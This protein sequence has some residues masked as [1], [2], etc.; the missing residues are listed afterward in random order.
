MNELIES[1]KQLRYTLSLTDD[2]D[3]QKYREAFTAA[4][5]AELN[6]LHA[7]IGDL[8]AMM[9]AQ[10]VPV[11]ER[12]PPPNQTVLVHY[13]NAAGKWRTV[14]GFHCGEKERDCDY[15]GNFEEGAD[16]SE[17]GE[18]CYW[19]AGWYEELDNWEDYS[20]VAICYGEPTH[21]MPL[22]EP[23]TC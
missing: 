13:T 2:D 11:S 17:D 20:A 3:I 22:P 4:H 8:L 5:A 6:N 12:L 9:V 19:P 23:P 14:C 10:W 18:V 16:W 21:W 1:L 15:Y 7:Q